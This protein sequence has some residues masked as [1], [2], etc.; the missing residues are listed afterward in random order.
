[1]PRPTVEE[2]D[3]MH[4]TLDAYIA[5]LKETEPEAYN[6]IGVLEEA[7]LELPFDVNEAFENG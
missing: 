6:T 5:H 3:I 2:W 1:M 4:D 7:A